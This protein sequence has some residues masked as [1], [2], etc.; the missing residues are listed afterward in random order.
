MADEHY[1]I[2][3]TLLAR[4]NSNMRK[5]QAPQSF[6]IT[7]SDWYTLSEEINSCKYYA[8]IPVLNLTA[9]DHARVDFSFNSISVCEVA[10]I[11]SAGETTN[12]KIILYS[13]EIPSD[14]INGVYIIQK[15]VVE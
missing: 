8:E 2:D 14:T 12:G 9:N 13:K 10:E 4:Y 11:C 1:I 5:E 7:V 3:L 15:G 6:S